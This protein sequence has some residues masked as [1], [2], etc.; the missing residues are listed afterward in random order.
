MQLTRERERVVGAR[1]GARQT[2]Q[3]RE[4]ELVAVVSDENVR[5][6]E[7][8]DA[9]PHFLEIRR[10]GDVAVGDVMRSRRAG[11][12]RTARPNEHRQLVTHDAVAHAD[13]RDLDDL[14]RRD[15]RVGGLEVDGREVAELVAERAHAQQL[16]CLEHCYRPCHPEERSDEGSAR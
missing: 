13:G 4:V 15:V 3:Q 6:A 16:S 10:V 2:A 7:L 1:F 11:G 12:D 14:G 8:G 9:R 5:P